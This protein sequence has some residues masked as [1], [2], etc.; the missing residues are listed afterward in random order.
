MKSRGTTVFA[1]ALAF[2]TIISGQG[3]AT[4][5]GG[6][7]DRPDNYYAAANRIQI[8]TPKSGDVVVAGREILGWPSL[9]APS[10]TAASI[11]RLSTDSGH[12]D[13]VYRL[14]G[15]VR[16]LFFWIASDEVGSARIA[17][18]GDGHDR[19]ISLLIGSDPSRAPRAINEWGYLREHAAGEST[20]VFGIRTMT[21]GDSPDDAEGKRIRADGLAEFGVLCSSVTA[22]DAW[23][24]TTTV[25]APNDATYRDTS[26]VLEVIERQAR[27]RQR[28]TSRSADVAPGFLTAMDRLMRSSLVPAGGPPIVS[29][30]A[31][32]YKDAIYDLDANR[33]ERVGVL[34]SASRVFRNVMRADITLKSRTAGSGSSF[35]IA[36]GTEGAL[37]GVLVWARYQPNWWFKIELE[38]DEDGQA[39]PE[40]ANDRSIRDR[41]A[42]ICN[43]SA[44]SGTSNTQ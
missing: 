20:T 41:I 1:I 13:R 9:V 30:R 12:V 5:E 32:V 33:V 21:D 44:H 35:S 11:A 23:S 39:P 38:L 25:Y 37:A 18:R 6:A 28:A 42:A 7:P 4:D 24:R 29:R 14:V 17:W 43:A 15:K 10:R 27:W 19:A 22:V 3:R 40:P 31:F 8:T 16:F 36:Y 2:A 34:Q 26:R